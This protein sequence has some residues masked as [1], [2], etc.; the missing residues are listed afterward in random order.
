MACLL[1]TKNKICAQTEET[2]LGERAQRQ[3]T[4]GKSRST[5]RCRRTSCEFLRVFR[6]S[7]QWSPVFT[8]L[9]HFHSNLFPT[10]PTAATS[11]LSSPEG[12]QH[13]PK[14]GGSR[15]AAPSLCSQSALA[16]TQRLL[17]Q[18]KHHPTRRLRNLLP[19]LSLCSARGT[20]LSLT[21]CVPGS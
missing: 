9:P 21:P 19:G 8:A 13:L 1:W 15:A 5:V 6:Y 12:Q 4:A 10:H 3:L 14:V 17:G 20:C 18:F 2:L 16:V 11:S 7:W